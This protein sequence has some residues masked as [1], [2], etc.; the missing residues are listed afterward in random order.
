MFEVGVRFEVLGIVALG[1]VALGLVV[2]SFGF[3][4]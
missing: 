4:F 2:L 3:W 1:C